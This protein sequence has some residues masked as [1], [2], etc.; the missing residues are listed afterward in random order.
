MGLPCLLNDLNKNVLVLQ[1]VHV[2]P[3]RNV[4]SGFLKLIFP[5][6]AASL[7]IRIAFN[8]GVNPEPDK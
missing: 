4:I 3:I 5:L 6:T 1:A 8:M 7:L 2:S